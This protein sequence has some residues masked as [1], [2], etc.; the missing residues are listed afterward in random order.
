M[1]SRQPARLA[2]I[3]PRRGGRRLPGLSR[4]RPRSR[5]GG[6]E[7]FRIELPVSD[8][9]G[10]RTMRAVRT[11]IRPDLVD[12]LMDLYCDW[13]EECAEV[14][15]AYERFGSAPK[16]DRAL[17]FA[18][19]GAALDREGT[20]SEA[21]AEHFRLLMPAPEESDELSATQRG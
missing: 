2:P 11:R 1:T 3:V 10:L 14:R 12:Q 20:A 18:A 7:P 5:L 15:S 4:E 9:G 6:D 13:R 21:Y 8:S 16:C 19:F 17:A